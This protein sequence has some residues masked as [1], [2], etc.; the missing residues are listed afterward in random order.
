MTSLMNLGSFV[1]SLAAGLFAAY[2]GRRHGL[3][4]A[5]VLNAIGVAVQLGATSAGQ[6]YVGRLFLGF[7]NGF[8]VTFASVYTAEA[9]PAH[10]RGSVIYEQFA[11][12]A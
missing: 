3:W 5:C 10:L 11:K 9:A 2:F 1:S 12:S 4:A 8:L 6:L 7:A